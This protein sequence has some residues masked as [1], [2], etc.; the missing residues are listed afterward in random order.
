MEAVSNDVEIVGFWQDQIE[1][2]LLLRPCV[3]P[4]DAPDFKRNTA[5]LGCIHLTILIIRR[6][7]VLA[8]ELALNARWNEVKLIFY[9][10]SVFV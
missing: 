1:L 7:F 8:V 5:S 3:V 10:L 6:R 2:R 9:R 4:A